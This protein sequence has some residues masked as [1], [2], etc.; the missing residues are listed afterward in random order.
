M[1]KPSEC[2]EC[3]AIVEELR[4]AKR[5]TRVS[6]KRSEE[7]RTHFDALRKMMAGSTESSDELLAKYPFRSQRPERLRMPEYG[8]TDPRVH[9]LVLRMLEHEARTGH[10]I[11]DLLRG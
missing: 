3:L 2:S 10:K 8:P 9:A 1:S 7:L 4:A 6:P 11:I 5:E